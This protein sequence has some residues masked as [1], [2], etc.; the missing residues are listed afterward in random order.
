MKNLSE[1]NYNGELDVPSQSIEYCSS[2]EINQRVQYVCEIVRELEE[3]HAR[4]CLEKYIRRVGMKSLLGIQL[5]NYYQRLSLKQPLKTSNFLSYWVNYALESFSRSLHPPTRTYDLIGESFFREEQ[6]N[7]NVNV[8]HD[9]Q[10]LTI[11]QNQLISCRYWGIWFN[12]DNLELDAKM[13]TF[14]LIQMLQRLAS[15]LS[16]IKQMERARVNGGTK[17]DEVR[18]NASCVGIDFSRIIHDVLNEKQH[19]AYFATLIEDVM[20][21]TDLR[22]RYPKMDRKRGAR[23]QISYASK[24]DYHYRKLDKMH[25]GQEY[26][27]LS[28]YGLAKSIFE[29]C[30]PQFL[31]VF[32]RTEFSSNFYQPTND[33]E[34]LALTLKC[35]FEYARIRA[36]DHP[37]GPMGILRPE[38][39]N[40]ICNVAEHDA[41][42][43]TDQMRLR[44]STMGTFLPSSKRQGR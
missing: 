11:K 24:A 22:L 13:T 15:D 38:L 6:C 5:L 1:L 3:A 23:V 19:I 32:D 34:E 12:T 8:I 39:K 41:F 21:R 9:G 16:C 4:G 10:K 28:P 36:T 42:L 29:G 25:L 20:E 35:N 44:E 30:S 27:F 33:V 14:V 17:L 43:T 40:I 26:V 2:N 31:S 37:M 18:I 7:I